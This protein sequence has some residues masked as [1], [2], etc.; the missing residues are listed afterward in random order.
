MLPPTLPVAWGAKETDKFAF[1]FGD[2]VMGKLGPAKLK[3]VPDIATREMVRFVLPVLT[4][5]TGTI[6]MLPTCTFPKLTFETEMDSWAWAALEIKSST[7]DEKIR[8]QQACP[9]GG[10]RRL[11][12]FALF[13]HVLAEHG[14]GIIGASIS[15]PS[16]DPCA[17]TDT[18]VIAFFLA[19]RICG[20]S[21]KS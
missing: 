4:M 13:L 15:A 3:P 20:R 10:P 11:M 21:P 14:R 16:E 9:W 18:P 1:C 19:G 7:R 6:W 12:L 2:R 5:P 8:I 17:G